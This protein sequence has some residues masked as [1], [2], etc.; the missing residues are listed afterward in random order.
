MPSRTHHRVAC[1]LEHLARQLRFYLPIPPGAGD[2]AALAPPAISPLG[3]PHATRTEPGRTDDP[4][5]DRPALP[6]R[7]SELDRHRAGLPA[8]LH[9]RD[10]SWQPGR[11]DDPLATRAAAATFARAA[12]RLCRRP[13]G[14]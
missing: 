6:D 8:Q 1:Q 7:E 9:R 14:G 12:H 2:T 11:N 5:H 4:D 13:A 3:V 10:W